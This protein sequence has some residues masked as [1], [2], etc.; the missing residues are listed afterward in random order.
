MPV[1]TAPHLIVG[2]VHHYAHVIAGVQNTTLEL[3]F[4]L[5]MVTIAPGW[6]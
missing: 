4:I 5:L 2:M 6:L 1:V 3:L